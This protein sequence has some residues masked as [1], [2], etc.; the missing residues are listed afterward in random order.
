MLAVTLT[1]FV[2]VGDTGVL[3]M[4]VIVGAVDVTVSVKLDVAVAAPSLRA[5]VWVAAAC[6]RVVGV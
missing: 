4:E 2:L 6:G 3:V 1:V 5:L